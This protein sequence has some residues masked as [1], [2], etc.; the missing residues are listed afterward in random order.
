MESNSMKLTK[1]REKVQLCY[2]VQNKWQPFQAY[3]RLEEKYIQD[4]LTKFVVV[5]SITTLASI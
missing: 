3:S 4:K 5:E 1:S 2:L